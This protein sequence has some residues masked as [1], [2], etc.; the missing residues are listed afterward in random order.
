[1]TDGTIE[2]LIGLLIGA[3]TGG[4]AAVIVLEV[5]DPSPDAPRRCVDCGGPTDETR[6]L[7]RW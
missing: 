6:G 2:F 3:A 4:L 1:M 5:Y 7:R